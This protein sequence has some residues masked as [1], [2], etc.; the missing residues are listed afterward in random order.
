MSSVL[1]FDHEQRKAL[2]EIFDSTYERLTTASKEGKITDHDAIISAVLTFMERVIPKILACYRGDAHENKLRGV[3]SSLRIMI[4]S[5]MPFDKF[6]EY[7]ARDEMKILD[8]MANEF[9]TKGEVDINNDVLQGLFK[10][11]DV[12]KNIYG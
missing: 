9:Q 5:I 11:D 2:D 3:A 8:I 6:Q 4:W 10:N 1:E 12:P 7:M